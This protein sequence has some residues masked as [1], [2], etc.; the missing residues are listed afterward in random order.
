[1]QPGAGWHEAGHTHNQTSRNAPGLDADTL[2]VSLTASGLS[3]AEHML[4][5]TMQMTRRSA[6]A[7]GATVACN[8]TRPSQMPHS[9]GT[10]QTLRA[11]R[12]PVIPFQMTAI[13]RVARDITTLRTNRTLPKPFKLAVDQR[14]RSPRIAAYK[15]QLVRHRYPS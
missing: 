11:K 5:D 2:D 4:H 3:Y 8:T 6:A 10:S 1:M 15:T 13:T 12:P 14:A 7:A 9:A